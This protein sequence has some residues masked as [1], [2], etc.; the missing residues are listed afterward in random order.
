MYLYDKIRLVYLNAYCFKAEIIY[1]FFHF[2]DYEVIKKTLI[3]DLINNFI[4]A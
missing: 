2:I 1:T 3:Y 4:N